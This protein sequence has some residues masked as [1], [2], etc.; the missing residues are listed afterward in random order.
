MLLGALPPA[1]FEQVLLAE[2]K[3]PLRL[4]ARIQRNILLLKGLHLLRR[5]LQ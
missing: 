4:T 1:R 2:V 3:P 5:R